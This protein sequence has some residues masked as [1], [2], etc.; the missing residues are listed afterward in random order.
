MEERQMKAVLM[1]MKV[2]EAYD[3]SV[4]LHRGLTEE[5]LSTLVSLG[6]FVCVEK[7]PNE[8]MSDTKYILT[9]EGRRFAWE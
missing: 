1:Q 9:D 2:G 5:D 4:L 8:T 6:C 3:K 7:N